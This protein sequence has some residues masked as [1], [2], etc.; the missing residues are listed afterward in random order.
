MSSAR[1]S[2]TS[3]LSTQEWRERD[4]AFLK[5]STLFCQADY[6]AL[7]KPTAGRGKRGYV[8]EG[9]TGHPV[10]ILRRAGDHV[11]ITPVSAYSSGDQNNNL[12]PWNQKFHKH[13]CR[14]DFRSFHG[15]ELASNGYP[16][17]FLEAGSMPK[18]KTSW[19]YIQSAW[20]VPLSVIT[21][22]TKSRQLL[23]LRQDSLDSL[24]RH[25]AERCWSWADC[26]QRLKLLTAPAAT[27]RPRTLEPTTPPT[28]V[29]ETVKETVPGPPTA[30]KSWAA[31]AAVGA[32]F[33]TGALP[34]N[35]RV[36]TGAS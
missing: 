9:A 28:V 18:P 27:V 34:G 3:T 8:P 6:D 24:C 12:A 7:V 35:S 13:K 23:R 16:A 11:L 17:L 30:A 26:Q 2:R 19:V 32:T 10:I 4:I 33:G 36:G 31:I 21:R 22:F 14:S 5:P 25:M 29:K 20:V 1:V 15:T